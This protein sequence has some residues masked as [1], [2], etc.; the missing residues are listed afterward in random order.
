MGDK[1]W[2]SYKLVITV[3]KYSG[4]DVPDDETLES[5]ESKIERTIFDRRGD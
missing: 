1:E 2:K 3:L 5:L 4:G